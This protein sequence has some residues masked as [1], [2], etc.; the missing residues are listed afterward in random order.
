MTWVTVGM[1]AVSAVSGIVG[2]N[3]ANKL[4]KQSLELQRQE[5]AFN[6][7]RYDD[8]QNQ[9]GGIIYLLVKGAEKGVDPNLGQVTSEASADTPS[10]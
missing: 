7:K 6:Q 2:S 3:K 1:G 9:Y 8:Y 5:L 10:V 4:S